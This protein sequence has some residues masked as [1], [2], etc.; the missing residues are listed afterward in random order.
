MIPK[1]AIGNYATEIESPRNFG[2]TNLAAC[3]YPVQTASNLLAYES[4]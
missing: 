2:I 4:G 1:R 3:L